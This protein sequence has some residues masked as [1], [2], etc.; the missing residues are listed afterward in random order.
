MADQQKENNA[1]KGGLTISANRDHMSKIG[2]KGG[3]SVSQN[4]DH[5]RELQRRST[6]KRIENIK[7]KKAAQTSESR[8]S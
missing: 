5:M 6:L 8:E 1:K 4:K 2:K 3:A 7:A